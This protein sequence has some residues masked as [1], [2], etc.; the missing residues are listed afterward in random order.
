MNHNVLVVEDNVVGQKLM[1]LML[2]KGGWQVTV[3]GNGQVS[4]P[5]RVQWITGWLDAE[6]WMDH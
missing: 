3:A 1:Q 2:V 5:F 4:K 6:C